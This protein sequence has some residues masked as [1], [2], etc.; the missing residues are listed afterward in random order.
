MK[1]TFL[2]SDSIVFDMK[3]RAKTDGTSLSAIVESAL[4]LF[5]SEKKPTAY[6]LPDCS[7]G[8]PTHDFP[9]DGLSWES[10]REE[11]YATPTV[12][13]LAVHSRTPRLVKPRKP[14]S[15]R[16]AK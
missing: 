2:L 14:K 4:R 1:T 13:T 8:N 11:I 3:R 6:T 7:V 10:L 5:L 16:S 9:L 15:I 12:E